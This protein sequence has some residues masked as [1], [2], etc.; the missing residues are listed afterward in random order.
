[1]ALMSLLLNL[2]LCS[3]FICNAQQ[4]GKPDQHPPLSYQDC[5]SGTCQTKN[6]KIVLD[7]NWRWVHNTGGYTNCYSGD[8]WDAQ[9]CP[10]KVGGGSICAQN[11]ALE[12][13][14]EGEYMSTY[15]IES[16]GDSVKIGFVTHNSNGENVGSRNYL[17]AEN[18]AEYEMFKLLNRQFSFDVDVS[19]LDCGLNGALYFVGM[20]QKGQLGQGNNNAG[21]AFGTGYCDAQCPQDVK[22]INGEANCEGWK[23][24]S[25]NPNS[26]LGKYGSCCNEMD[27]WEA[28][29]ISTAVTPHACSGLGPFRCDGSSNADG[30]CGNTA[31]SR[32]TSY[33]DADGCDYNPWRVGNQTFYGNTTSS[34][35]NTNEKLTVITQFITSDNTDTGD[36][37]EIRRYFSQNGNTYSLPTADQVD[38][39]IDSLTDDFCTKAKKVFGDK[40]TFEEKGGLKQMGKQM[41]EGMVLVM[42]LW[43]DYAVDMLWLDSCYPP[44]E[45]CSKPG[46]SR[47]PCPPNSGNP[48]YVEK[49]DAG[50]STTFG[51]IKLGKIQKYEATSLF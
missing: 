5:S 25:G 4:A 23:P 13:V 10:S 32:Y 15:G 16:E 24:S 42:S 28:N 14:T 22:F 21:A 2:V 30:E 44:T 38:P 51:S 36:L 33:C 8:D 43:D 27:I 29:R 6:T 17:L 7:A 11:C 48:S 1:M 34:L 9:Y 39:G 46:V 45:D 31:D 18:G 41:A 47:G 49:A 40:A 19:S 20:D 26:G 3:L 35:L 12:G 50:A 37:V